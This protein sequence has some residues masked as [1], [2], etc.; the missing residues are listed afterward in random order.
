ML[1]AWGPYLA[2]FTL[3][4]A[5]RAP[6][7]GRCPEHAL[8]LGATETE[9][10]AVSLARTGVLGNV[11]A[12]DGKPSAHAAP[13]YPW[14]LAQLYRVA[15]RCGVDPRPCQVAFVT[16]VT[17]GAL[18]LVP[19][20]ARRAALHPGAGWAAA[21]LLA[22][23]P[24]NRCLETTGFFEQP[25]LAVALPVVLLAFLAL[26]ECGWRSPPRVAL[27]A[28]VTGVSALLGP[29]FLSVGG[30]VLLAELLTLRGARRRVL[31]GAAVIV[32][33]TALTLFPWAYRNHRELGAWVWTRGNF[34]LELWIG[35]NPGANGLT[36]F[37][38]YDVCHPFVSRTEAREYRRLGEA[39]YMRRK[40]EA[41]RAWIRANPGGFARLTA[42]RLRWFWFPSRHMVWG[43][44]AKWVA[45]VYGAL[46]L[47]MLAG[48]FRLFRTAHPHRWLLAAVL[49][50]FALPY[51]VTHV[52]AR[53]R[54]PLCG[55]IDVLACD[56]A[57]R[58]ALRLRQFADGSLLRRSGWP[59]K[60]AYFISPGATDQTT[61]SMPTRTSSK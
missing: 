60:R 39:A 19:V 47:G 9:R 6:H 43:D 1:K 12:D 41:A 26:H 25:L 21:V 27:A 33:V 36:F 55:V 16:L 34:G 15:D 4:L 49:V 3:A 42:L 48:L 54:Y 50:G 20:L 37:P 35:N 11:F 2:L 13:L 18:C 45:Y 7:L 61:P 29:M 22:V 44:G 31:L 38:G 30:L 57:V 28:L 53:Y 32:A 56:F 10:A 46:T 17:C 14:L 58:A 59:W 8:P 40:G 51:L 52:D 24:G 5:V 23:L